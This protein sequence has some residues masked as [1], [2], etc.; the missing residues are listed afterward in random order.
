MAAIPA[1]RFRDPGLVLL[2]G[3][4]AGTLDLVV[5]CTFWGLR[6]IAPARIAQSIASGLLGARAFALGAPSALLG[7]ALH[8]LIAIAFIAAFRIALA[9]RPGLARHRL[10]NGLAYGVVLFLAMNYVVLPLSAAGP[11]AFQHRD[12][13][14]VSIAVHLAIGVLCA[15]FA[16]AAFN[17]R[18]R[19][20]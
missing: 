15:W 4:L 16:G 18:R 12:W 10:R 7:L 3:L 9:A 6:G 2:G 19:A 11:P 17:A 14:A 13:L 20:P 8:F 5:A 1:F